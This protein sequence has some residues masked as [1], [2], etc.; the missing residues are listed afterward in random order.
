MILD[1][2]EQAV[3]EVPSCMLLPEFDDKLS[4]LTD[5]DVTV[6]YFF[7]DDSDLS[8]ELIQLRD[9]LIAIGCPMSLVYR[10]T[11]FFH[12]DFNP[13]GDQESYQYELRHGDLRIYRL[14]IVRLENFRWSLTDRKLISG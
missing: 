7:K 4:E 8:F 9:W 10:I 2:F 3:G 13:I 11:R 1:Y 14:K 6:R 12:Y 5:N